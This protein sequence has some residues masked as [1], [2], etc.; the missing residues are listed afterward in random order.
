MSN[1]SKFEGC[2][3]FFSGTTLMITDNNGVEHSLPFSST[4]EAKNWARNNKASIA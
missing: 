1:K 2:V 3:G 4:N